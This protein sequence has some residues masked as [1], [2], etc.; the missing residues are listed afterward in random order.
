MSK[1]MVIAV[2]A[3]AASGLVFLAPFSGS[4]FGFALVNATHM[5]LFLAGL[6]LGVSAVI[7]A[8]ATATVIITLFADI[9]AAV[10]FLV[11][12]AVPTIIVVRQALLSRPGADGGVEWYP[13]GSLL[14]LL[15][16]YGAATF[17][18]AAAMTSNQTTGL[19]GL[20][21]NS[22]EEGL[23][24][25]I[26]DLPEETRQMA[27]TQWAS[28]LPAMLV[29]SWLVTVTV[30]GTLAQAIL[31]R[32]NRNLRPS[33]RFSQIAVP[34]KLVFAVALCAVGWLAANGT[35]AYMAKDLT[36]ILAVP[37]FFQGLGV[38]HEVSRG[39]PGRGIALTVFYILVLFLLDWP[40]LAAIAGLGLA[41]QWLGLR[42]RFA[43]QA[44]DE[45]ED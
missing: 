31:I 26:P 3:G 21:R 22:L 28:V 1:A 24:F 25:F 8:S 37:Y 44:A 12:F 9:G 10:P 40:G 20:V 5:P 16:V 43:G 33:P 27:A 32:G 15:A 39:W 17:V 42:R 7:T 4:M 2:A 6:G 11:A 18:I 19:E 34:D 23:A 35:V 13:P 30:N 38:V 36:I 14:S 29:C 45:E 41:E